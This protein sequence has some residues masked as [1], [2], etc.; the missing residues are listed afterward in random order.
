MM[1]YAAAV[2]IAVDLDELPGRIAEFGWAYLLTVR[3]D[4]RPHVVAVTPAW[5]GESLVISVGRGTAANA[6]SRPMVTLCYPP[7]DMSGFSLVIDGKATVDGDSITVRP[8]A[9]VL[10]R[11]APE[12]A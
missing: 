4:Q 9:A 11:P 12:A 5:H 10:H 8:T 3:D 2:S 1:P 7:V 6:A